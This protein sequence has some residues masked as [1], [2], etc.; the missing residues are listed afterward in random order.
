MKNGRGRHTGYPA[1]V[2]SL[3]RALSKLGYCSRTEA[4][5]LIGEGKVRVN[6]ECERDAR[7]RVSTVRDTIDVDGRTLESSV[8]LMYILMNKPTG[9][10]TSRSDERG[11]KSV[12]DVLGPQ[13]VWVHPVGRLDKESSG[14]LLFTSDSGFSDLLTDPATRHPKSYR[15][16]VD[17]PIGEDD[18]A[19]LRR[20]VVLDDGY[21]TL[22]ARVRRAEGEEGERSFL[23]TI[24]EGK[25]RQI[26]RMCRSLGFE[27][28]TLHR[29]AVGRLSLGDL[30]PG[31]WRILTEEE[32]KRALAR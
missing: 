16:S 19:E 25:N 14:L 2:V 31:K 13:P 5:R 1:G 6:G 28:V 30:G 10:V 24:T 4:E 27:V 21:R 32:K 8:Q 20:G 23:M 7:R 17:R 15:V 22:P 12:Y 29:Y 11:A 26:R 18:L 3:P 9:V